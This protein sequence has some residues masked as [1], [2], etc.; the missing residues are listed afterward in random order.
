MIN[1]YT[2]AAGMTIF[3]RLA[4]AIDAIGGKRRKKENPTAEAVQKYNL[5]KAI[6]DLAIL[7]NANFSGGDL[8]ITL[9]YRG[10][11]PNGEEAKRQLNNFW[12]RLRR[13]YRGIG[14]ELKW[15]AATEYKN[16]RIHHHIVINKGIAI[17]EIAKIWGNGIL[18]TS[19]MDESGDYR[20]LAE[21]MIK[22]TEKTFRE[23][24]AAQRQRYSCSRNL[25]R[26]IT[27]KEEVSAATMLRKPKPVKGYYIDQ[28][29]I[30]EGTNPV[31][32]MPYRE[33]VMI[34]L[35]AEPRLSIWQRGERVKELAGDVW[36]RQKER[37]QQLKITPTM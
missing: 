6:R 12:K 34:A 7:L 22:E 37:E 15:V 2:T 24:D 33:Y 23:T 26:P 4:A 3:V 10:D 16:K 35:D 31:T 1:R 17:E 21:Y 14:K 32:G 8:H 30:Y 36:I 28:D 25:V 9:T 20:K 29:S 5:K 13:A 27:K 18:R 11:E 19:V